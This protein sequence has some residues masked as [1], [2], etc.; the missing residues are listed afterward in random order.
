MGA[1]EEMGDG[2]NDDEVFAVRLSH[3]LQS[4]LSLAPGTHI[5]TLNF[6]V[7]GYTPLAQLEQMK[8]KVFGFKPDIVLLFG[9]EEFRGMAT[10]ALA[11]AILKRVEPQYSF[12]RETIKKAGVNPSMSIATIQRKLDPYWK[13]ILDGAYKEM[14]ALCQQKNIKPVFVYLPS[15]LQF[16]RSADTNALIEMAERNG[17]ELMDLSGIYTGMDRFNLVIAP[18]DHHPNPA[19]HRLIADTIAKRLISGGFLKSV[20]QPGEASVRTSFARGN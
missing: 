8:T 11:K 2:V 19:G 16:E 3:Q 1:S 7:Y 20:Q 10:R 5:E 12:L 13:E 9:H 18:W 15:V 17:Y 4:S 6:S 14:A